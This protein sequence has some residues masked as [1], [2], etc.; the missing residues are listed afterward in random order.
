MLAGEERIELT[1]ANAHE[2]AVEAIRFVR[3]SS[4]S[5]STKRIDN[6]A[7]DSLTSFYRMLERLTG[8]LGPRC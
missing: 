4:T 2:A 1:S 8:R 7:Q 6:G 5:S 3:E